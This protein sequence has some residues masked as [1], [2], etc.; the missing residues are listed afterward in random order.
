MVDDQEVL[1]SLAEAPRLVR[2]EEIFAKPSAVPAAPGLYVWYF[3]RLPPQVRTEG[4]VSLD[5][6]TLAYAGI[7]P[8][9]RTSSQDLRKRLKYHY[10]GNAEGSTLR[11]TL[12]CLLESELDIQL[13]R[14]GSG[15]RLTFHAG[16]QR[17]TAW[18]AE[19]TRV[20]WITHPEPWVAEPILI[21]AVSLPLNLEHN[22]G[23]GFARDLSDC[24]AAARARARDLPIVT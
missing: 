9:N 2:R 20:A 8:K 7:S 23:H 17:L 5:G 22:S 13:R 14:V 21:R 12:G 24:R 1:R 4:C 10:G 3:D 15:R 11:M 19:H 18:M 6:W 16:E